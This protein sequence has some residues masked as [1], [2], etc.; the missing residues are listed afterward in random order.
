VLTRFFNGLKVKMNFNYSTL[1]ILVI[2]AVS[3]TPTENSDGQTRL[4]LHVTQEELNIWKQRRVNG[5]YQNQWAK[6]QSRADAFVAAPEPRWTART[7]GGCWVLKGS[8]TSPGRTLDR[9]MRDAGLMYLLTGSAAYRHAVRTALLAQA[10]V[11]GTNFATNTSVWCRR[12]Y[13]EEKYFEIGN[14][15]RRL[16]YAYDYIRPSLSSA[17]KATLDTWFLDAANHVDITMNNNLADRFL[18]RLSD[19]YTCTG[20]GFCPGAKKAVTH[21][22]GP[23]VYKFHAGWENIPNTGAAFVGAVGI[24]QNNTL[25][26]NKAKK[27]FDEW[28][29]YAVFP[30]GTVIDQKR[31]SNNGANPQTAYLYAGTAIGTMITLA[32]HFARAGDLS[33]YNFTTQIGL[34]GSESPGNPKSLLQVMQNFAGMTNGT[35][36]RYAS[37]VPTTDPTKRIDSLGTIQNNIEHIFLAPG[38]LFFKDPSVKTAYTKSLPD[39]WFS[40]GYDVL[41]GEWGTYPTV[42][43]MFGQM[44]DLVSPY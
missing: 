37:T 25:L 28:L 42:L 15:L 17:D 7:T 4:G 12:N 23:T 43:G 32:D 13:Y 38:N 39:S 34:F 36:V 20:T 27:Y 14:W 6:I 44:E 24:Q 10:A 29:K 3:V 16:L 9:G 5:P 19:N 31:W 30:G 41:G 26:R 40:G 1:A 18:N 21:F 35:I 33:L 8:D 2:L 11:A 22:G